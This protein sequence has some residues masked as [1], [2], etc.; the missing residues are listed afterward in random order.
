VQAF[1]NKIREEV[2]R[3]YIQIA[4]NNFRKREEAN[5]RSS[6]SRRGNQISNSKNSSNIDEYELEEGL[7]LISE[8]IDPMSYIYFQV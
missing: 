2:D 3:S 8:I 1:I 7:Q 6:Q 5:Q 4:I